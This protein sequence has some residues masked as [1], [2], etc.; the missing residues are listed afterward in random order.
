MAVRALWRG[1]LAL[2]AVHIPVKLYTAV[3]EAR[4]IH[5]DMLHDADGVKLQQRMVCSADGQAVPPEHI[6]RGVQVA[7]NKYVPV[8]DE[9]LVALEP[10][11]DRSVEVGPFVKPEE[12]DARLYNRAYY[13]G[14]DEGSDHAYQV[15]RQALLKAE[16][17]GVCHW[18]MR[19]RVYSGVLQARDDV[20][21][22]VT[23]RT[24]AELVN[25][26][27]E[28]A[29]S[30]L[31]ERELKTAR[32]LIEAFA[33]DFDPAKYTDDYQQ[34]L[35]ELIEKKAAGKRI[36]ASADT[37][38]SKTTESGQ[39]LTLLEASLKAAQARNGKGAKPAAAAGRSKKT[40]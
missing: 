12:V 40:G 35:R 5:F 15:L 25:A 36:V 20:L 7:R 22:L 34:E 6:V 3:S 28:G 39:L 17:L 14:P 26:K 32:Y 19:K 24:A 33:S 11:S 27:V 16:R 10:E 29:A 30:A 21:C 1:V 9:K 18:V 37:G 8:P 4:R 2:G 13:L 38:K 23:L 31:D